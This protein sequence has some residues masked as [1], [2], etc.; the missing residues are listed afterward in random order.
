LTGR[1]ALIAQYAPVFS[2]YKPAAEVLSRS[3]R[4]AFVAD[5]ERV[6]AQGH[7][8][9]SQAIYQVEG[10]KIRRVRFMP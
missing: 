4:R 3:S 5:H 8:L 2:R 1:A 7:A 10:G 9:E 6:T